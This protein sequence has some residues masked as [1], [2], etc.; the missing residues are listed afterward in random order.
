MYQPNSYDFSFQHGQ[1]PVVLSNKENLPPV[2]VFS[3]PHLMKVD[4][5]EPF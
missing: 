4:L 2:G 1:K 5:I 3:R